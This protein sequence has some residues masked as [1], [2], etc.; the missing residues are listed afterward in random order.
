MFKDQFFFRLGLLAAAALLLSCGGGEISDFGDTRLGPEN[1]SVAPGVPGSFGVNED[2]LPI[3]EAGEPISPLSDLPLED[4]SCP[5][6]AP[7]VTTSDSW[8][9]TKASQVAFGT[10]D[11]EVK[12]R[13]GAANLD[14]ILA[15]GGQD[16]DAFADAAILVRFASDGL[17]DARD[18]SVYDKDV[19]FPYEPG[20]WYDIVVSANL[21]T[22]TYDVKV[23]QCGEPLQELIAGAAFRSD[24][25]VSDQ[26]TTWAT[27][28]SKSAT[29][30]VSTPSWVASGSC[31][32]ATCQSLGHVCGQ[33][34]DGCGGNLSCGDCGSSEAC[35]SGMCV[36]APANPSPPPPP[37]CTPATCQSLGNECGQWGDECGG[38]LSCGVCS[39][40]QMCSSGTCIDAPGN[41]SP[42]PP[43]TGTPYG[44]VTPSDV[45][46]TIGVGVI[47]PVPTAPYT[48]PR[49]I[50][51]N[52]TLI[53]NVVLSECPIIRANNVTLRN[54]IV[55]ARS[56][57]CVD[58]QGCDGCVV[59]YS[60]VISGD[61]DKQFR[62]VDSTNIYVRN[63]ELTGGQDLFWLGQS[64]DNIYIE[65]NYLHSLVGGS[66]NHADGFQGAE[67]AVVYPGNIVIRGNYFDP[68]NATIGKTDILFL[69]EPDIITMENNFF[70]NWGYYTLRCLR[71]DY[72]TS[73]EAC[74]IRNNIYSNDFIAD[75][76]TPGGAGRAVQLDDIDKAGRSSYEC[77]RY[78]NGDFIEQE[79]ISGPITHETTGCPGYP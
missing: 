68:N 47:A 27:Y 23:G 73:T 59:E 30:E 45:G 12:A 48:G 5:S 72:D 31:A 19:T 11:F 49:E 43:P 71:S 16:I 21:S 77:N 65:N 35:V 44:H 51:T 62:I 61:T 25:A 24:A 1:T 14:G 79:W 13:P 39:D 46:V 58:I 6:V 60:K 52:G 57:K 18:G 26:L 54:V 64:K 76:V 40:G 4:S 55:D 75:F 15:I 10:L 34:S 28:T 36:D 22:S 29:I 42:P 17:M 37:S 8:R 33:A 3:N 2:G 53:E 7:D 78:E 20:V 9:S 74:H 70:S 56:S 50:T 63:S 32:P 66:D 67:N 41:P 69:A 38:I